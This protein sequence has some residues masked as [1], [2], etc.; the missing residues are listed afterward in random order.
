MRKLTT[1][2]ELPVLCV[3]YRTGTYVWVYETGVAPQ[4]KPPFVRY[5]SQ[6]GTFH[7]EECTGH[8]YTKIDN[9]VRFLTFEVIQP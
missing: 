4:G 6:N 3:H 7:V 5:L 9:G 2:T 8:Q 1:K